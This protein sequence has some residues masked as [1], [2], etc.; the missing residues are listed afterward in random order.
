MYQ[1]E[2]YQ[3]RS[4]YLLRTRFTSVFRHH[5]VWLWFCKEKDKLLFGLKITSWNLLRCQVISL[6]AVNRNCSICY[7]ICKQFPHYDSYFNIQFSFNFIYVTTSIVH[8]DDH[9]KISFDN[10][11]R[12]IKWAHFCDRLNIHLLENCWKYQSI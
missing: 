1:I 4:F 6:N 11:I 3:K 2:L 8:P 7:P 10:F 12:S 9:F 5:C